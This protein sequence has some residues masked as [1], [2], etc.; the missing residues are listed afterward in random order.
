MQ[1][2]VTDTYSPQHERTIRY[3]DPALGIEWPFDPA[4]FQLSDKDRRA[5][6]LADADLVD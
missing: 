1:Y 2:K 6:L 4:T 5:P 3:D